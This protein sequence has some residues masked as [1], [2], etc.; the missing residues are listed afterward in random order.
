[1]MSYRRST[2]HE[3]VADAHLPVVD[4]IA[5]SKFVCKGGKFLECFDGRIC[6][7]HPCAPFSGLVPEV[8]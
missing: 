5:I 4:S 3:T 1:M 7:F 6:I 2:S 8:A